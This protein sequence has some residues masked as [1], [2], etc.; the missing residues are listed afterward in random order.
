MSTGK[1]HNNI[2]RSNAAVSDPAAKAEGG[3]VVAVVPAPEAKRESGT[4]R[5]TRGVA[6]GSPKWVQTVR[7]RM[8]TKNDWLHVHAVSSLVRNKFYDKELGGVLNTSR[9]QNISY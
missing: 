9:R 6:G 1:P 8:L 5:G 7:R 3:D 2:P 4:P